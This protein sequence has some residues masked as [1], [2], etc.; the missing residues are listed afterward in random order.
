MG[1]IY[2]IQLNGCFLKEMAAL[3]GKKTTNHRRNYH[4]FLP[5]LR[6]C[7]E[8]RTCM[9]SLPE[10]S[11]RPLPPISS[12]SDFF[13]FEDQK[14]T[15]LLMNLLKSKNSSVP[16]DA[17]FSLAE[18]LESLLKELIFNDVSLRRL[19]GII[20]Q[21]LAERWGHTLAILDDIFETDEISR[22]LKAVKARI[23]NFANLPNGQDIIAAGIR[24][25]N[26]YVRLFLKHVAAS[27]NGALV[28]FGSE[29]SAHKNYEANSILMNAIDSGHTAQWEYCAPI[30]DNPS[31]SGSS[32][33]I[34]EFKTSAE[35]AFAVALAIRRALFENQSVLVVSPHRRLAEKIKK[36]LLRWNI[37]A[38][39]SMGHP[40]SKTRSGLATALAMDLISRQSDV[41]SVLDLL[42]S[43]QNYAATAQE[44]EEFFRKRPAIP[45][46][47][48][49]ALNLWDR[50]DENPD[51]SKLV[52]KM[53]AFRIDARRRR[54][55][56]EWHSDCCAILSMINPEDAAQLLAVSE[57]ILSLQELLPPMNF[58]EFRIFFANRV[59]AAPQRETDSY[60]EG[61]T[62]LGAIEAQLLDADL[63][64]IAGA[65]E[66]SWSESE[67]NDFWLTKSMLKSL[68]IQSVET[69]ND[70]FRSIFERLW[71]KNQVLVTR[72]E[73]INGLPQ[74]KYRF[75]EMLNRNQSA[76]ENTLRQLVLRIRK[77]R[78][79][80]M[81]RFEEPNPE[82]HCR[83]RKL[84]ASDVD[85]LANNPYA[86]YAKRILRLSE[87][88]DINNP[89]SIRGNYLHALLESFIKHSPD[90]TDLAKLNSIAEKILKDRWLKPSQLGLWFFRK[91]Q[92]FAFVVAHLDNNRKY[93]AE[94]SGDFALQI[95]PD[96]EVRIGCR[97]DRIDLSA[98]GDLSI[99]D[100]KTGM[101]PSRNK[102]EE[103]IRVQLPVEALIAQ[104][105]GFG[106]ERTS[107]EKLI[108]WRL[109]GTN[110]GEEKIICANRTETEKLCAKTCASLKKMINKYNVLGSSYAPN[111]DAPYDRAYLHLARVKEW[112]NAW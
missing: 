44:L 25:A 26:H 56:A 80:E 40:F 55:F 5:N 100:Y 72:S 83:P 31:S 59:L 16:A 69:L 64:I 29:S 60:T 76:A 42:K 62:I 103:G 81:V 8:L 112:R 107:V 66:E 91:E 74:R 85:L 70:F 15:L 65:N 6:S 96:C 1:T 41:R 68:K 104:N 77:S 39:D 73:V 10:W 87:L 33:T 61:V 37:F 84:W 30:T 111:V 21:N 48:F 63:V 67:N 11:G 17:L 78:E 27:Q 92:T 19:N 23:V 95:S 34:E 9:L 110:G 22:L 57:G 101:T 13:S 88:N 94:I 106:I 58:E 3:I 93:F 79:R 36:E 49:A 90:K 53:Q 54:T 35:E 75:L 89:K 52:A 86:F 20:P 24:D 4:V 7:R 47:F 18:S 98:D 82:L 99:I 97:A 71:H 45:S 51:F 43:S 32:R 105:D 12:V 109:G 28:V 38:D 108:F 50:K 46:D 102:I 2:N 14:M